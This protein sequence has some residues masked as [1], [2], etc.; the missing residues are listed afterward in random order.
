[1]DHGP[2][3]KDVLV[4]LAAAGLVVPLFHRARI[5]AV[6]GFLCVGIAVGPHGFGRLAEDVPWIRYLTIEDRARVEPFAELG[7]LFL[8]FLIGLELSLARLWSLRRYVAG[9]GGLQFVIAALVI[10]AG[11]AVLGAPGSGAI[12][13]G[14]CLAMSSTAIVMQLLEEQ[15]RSTTPVGRVALAV[16]LFQD[17]MVAP[18]LFGVQILARGEQNVAVSLAGAL[19]QAVLAVVAILAAGRYV[20]QPIFRFAAQTGSRELIMA[21]TLFMVVGVAAATGVAGL[22]TALGAFLAGLLLS[23]TEYRHQIE[24]DIAP[25]KGLLIGL[26][27]ITVGMTIDISAVWADIGL[28][29][30]AVVALLAVKSLVLLVASRT[31][32]VS[33]AIAA[34]VAILLAQGGEFAFV[35]IGLARSGGVLSGDMTQIASAVVGISMMV[36]PLCARCGAWLGRG[37]QHVDHR[38]HMPTEDAKELQ[39][40]VVIGGYGRV[41]QTVARLLNAENV[42]FVALDTN[43]E[44]VNECRKRGERCYFGDAG[45]PEFLARVGAARARAFVVTVNAREAAERMA[46]AA[47]KQRPDALLFARAIDAEHAIRLLRLGAVDV[48]PEAVEASLQLGGRLLEGLGLSDDAVARRLDELREQELARLKA[49][50]EE[51]G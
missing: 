2:W 49:A 3:L 39:D 14:L 43:G 50:R 9:I 1:M 51:G 36:T 34:E 20:L 31:F 18:V 5:G 17:L 27:F 48:I 22:S 46:T 13:L 7:V 35:V 38:H 12:V 25:F 30:A 23:E 15:G 32:G 24:I 28:V 19:L 29:L 10:G 26:F 45:R 6:L 21:I 41:G 42:P 44:V 8:L 40:H 16:L 11:L 47:R 37:L 4:F 33:L